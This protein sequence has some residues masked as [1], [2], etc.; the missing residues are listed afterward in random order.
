MDWGGGGGGGRR[1]LQVDEAVEQLL[2]VAALEG[3]E[4]GVERLP[5]APLGQPGSG[6]Q[7]APN[8]TCAT[9]I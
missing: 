7:E 6:L 1:W 4:Q 3:V 9:A 5:P 2:C 8:N